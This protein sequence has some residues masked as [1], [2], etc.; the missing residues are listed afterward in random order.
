MGEQEKCE[1]EEDEAKKFQHCKGKI[2]V[3]PRYISVSI[4]STVRLN[5]SCTV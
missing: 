4:T 2:N 1:L 3:S 5:V